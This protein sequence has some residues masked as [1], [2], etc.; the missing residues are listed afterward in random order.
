V[1]IFQKLIGKAPDA[2]E[3]VADQKVRVAVFHMGDSRLELLEGT[4][5]DSPIT[6]FISKHGEGI[7]HLALSV[8][9]LPGALR[10]LESEGV[11]LVDSAP[12]V[13]AG[14]EHIAF[15]HPSSTTGVLIELV[16]EK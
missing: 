1:P 4:G 3:T 8:P 14:N 10:K 7:H 11:R 2:E 9:D 5:S 16:E 12:R 15:L 13:G 6:R